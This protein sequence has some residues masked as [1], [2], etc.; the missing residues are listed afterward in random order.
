MKLKE[1]E[2][3]CSCQLHS[4]ILFLWECAHI[5]TQMH[6][7]SCKKMRIRC[8][9]VHLCQLST[10]FQKSLRNILILSVSK[11]LKY[12]EMLKCIFHTYCG[13]F[14]AFSREMVESLNAFLWLNWLSSTCDNIF[15][16]YKLILSN[17]AIDPWKH[18]F[19]NRKCMYL[20]AGSYPKYWLTYNLWRETMVIFIIFQHWNFLLLFG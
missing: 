18:E 8:W 7:W 19:L 5:C 3:V 13:Q 15:W 17:I 20:V 2:S 12:R 4:V 9:Q 1:S 10:I 16:E 11:Y 14:L 6:D